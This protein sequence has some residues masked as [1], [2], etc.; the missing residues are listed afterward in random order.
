MTETVIS[1]ALVLLLIF[2]FILPAISAV[3]GSDDCDDLSIGWKQ[4]CDDIEKK[5]QNNTRIIFGI[6]AAPL[7]GLFIWIWRAMS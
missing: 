2:G 1:A 6:V 5:S 4:V 7:A 3:G